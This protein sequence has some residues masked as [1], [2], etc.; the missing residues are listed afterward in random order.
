MKAP[1]AILL[2]TLMLFGCDQ[3][4]SNTE[5]T[6]SVANKLLDTDTSAMANTPKITGIGGIFFHSDDP[7]K[8]KEWYGENLG[9]AVDD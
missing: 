3:N 7:N 5:N 4:S 6:T 1:L 8:T 9:L 2:V